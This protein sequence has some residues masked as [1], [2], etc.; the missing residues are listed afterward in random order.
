MHT[1]RLFV[2][3]VS[4]LALL[5][6]CILLATPAAAA[7]CIYVT[8]H[9]SVAQRNVCLSITDALQFINQ[10][11]VQ[12]M[13]EPGLHVLRNTSTGVIHGFNGTIF[14]GM[15]SNVTLTC[16]DNIGLV[17][18][19]SNQLTIQ[20]LTITGCSMGADQLATVTEH[21][22]M[23]FEQVITIPNDLNV[24]L[25]IADS[26]DVRI[27]SVDISRMNG[28]GLVGLN[29]LGETRIS[30][31]K[32]TSNKPITASCPPLD[33]RSNNTD[34]IAGGMFLLYQDYQL[35]TPSQPDTHN[36]L[37]ILNCRFF[38][39]EDCSDVWVP[40]IFN[41]RT[42][43]LDYSFGGGGGMTL[44][45]AQTHYSV[46]SLIQSSNFQSNI[47][48]F[49]SG[50]HIGFFTGSGNSTVVFNK[51]TFLNNGN[52]EQ[53]YSGGGIAVL[54]DLIRPNGT[55]PDKRSLT[56]P[57]LTVTDTNFTGNSA[58]Y[59]GGLYV[60]TLTGSGDIK[61]PTSFKIDRCNFR[62]NR[63]PAASAA[64]VFNR[65]GSIFNALSRT[66]IIDSCFDNN[67]ANFEEAGEKNLIVGVTFLT[68]GGDVV[69]RGNT[70]FNGNLGSA[71]TSSQANIIIDGDITIAN[72]TG[73]VGSLRLTDL[74]KLI[75]KRN[76]VLTFT[77][78]AAAIYG[79]AIYEGSQGS[80]L[81]YAQQ[82]CF[83]Y[84]EQVNTL[85]EIET[86]PDFASL[87]VT[88]IFHDNRAILGTN[89]YGSS[90]EKCSWVHCLRK[91]P[92]NSD[93]TILKALEHINIASVTRTQN[94]SSLEVSTLPSRINIINYT[95]EH[96]MPGQEFLVNIIVYDDLDQSISSGLGSTIRKKDT[97]V[98]ENK[99]FSRLGPNGF[100][101]VDRS[102]NNS[103]VSRIPVTIT[104]NQNQKL[105]VFV[106]S[107]DESSNAIGSFNITLTDCLL[108]FRY[109]SDKQSCVCQPVFD[110]AGVKCRA[111]SGII[112]LYNDTWV[113]LVQD[114]NESRLGYTRCTV[115]FCKVGDINITKDN[116]NQR[117][118]DSLN[119]EG[120]G[121]GQCRANFSSTFGSNQCL[122]CTNYYLFLIIAFIATGIGTMFVLSFF[123]I[124]IAEGYLN[125]VLFYSN[126]ID[127]FAVFLVPPNS[128]YI[129]AFIP[130]FWISQNLG[131]QACFFDGMTTLDAYGLRFAYV[132]YLLILMV[133]VSLLS[134]FIQLPTSFTYS[135][136]KVF[137]TLL[138]LCYISLL[139]T[140]VSIFAFQKVNLDNG[141]VLISWYYDPNVIYFEGIHGVLFALAVITM[142][143]YVI[144]F[145]ILIL[146]PKLILRSKFFDRFKPLLDPFWAPLKPGYEWW[147]AFRLVLRW[148][149]VFLNVFLTSLLSIV[150]TLYILGFCLICLLFMQ[151]KLQPFSGS[152]RN[153]FDDLLL[154]NL[155]LIMTGS[156]PLLSSFGASA[157]GA[158]LPIV[159]VSL[160]YVVFLVIL[161]FQIDQT[162]PDIRNRFSK[163]LKKKKAPA[164][165][166][167]DSRDKS[168]SNENV[169]HSEVVVSPRCKTKGSI[170][171]ASP[172]ADE[173]LCDRRFVSYR[174][175]L[176]GDEE[177]NNKGFLSSINKSTIETS[178]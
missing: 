138:I 146:S 69:L 134:R 115:N 22:E 144:P 126:I 170:R 161:I 113:G 79:G 72:T 91:I 177:E 53:Y 51:C 11:N 106:G 148:I 127:L 164:P 20:D 3:L 125:S 139:E 171:F 154:T 88:M 14:Q 156:V 62:E 45:N 84:F 56:D 89:I 178:V 92:G 61:V 94:E 34:S 85:P 165:E 116:F 30:G 58:F 173:V 114:G 104:G 66:E 80:H 59:G 60:Y 175:S 174:E 24:G 96:V 143:V 157:S 48:K 40:E 43:Q 65:E 37:T 117:C 129:N 1:M 67:D 147:V 49:G 121:C 55:R 163:W 13:F 141:K 5:D 47:A 101:F 75:L 142:V 29:L 100:Q 19:Q 9:A 99:A 152:S 63:A 98:N 103:T 64:L 131:I 153:L 83:L 140:C 109:D 27:E 149:P 123:R 21:A 102:F 172:D 122:E 10:S 158:V 168:P 176:L 86:C 77:G 17:F 70:L 132:A 74:A 82:G 136:T 18:L 95:E 35:D 162:H 25:L 108:G 90:L 28:I 130:L 120:V 160:A 12:L 133:L 38:D 8:G 7:P 50:A 2:P 107:T 73:F 124:S 4:T 118:K 105:T 145:P 31:V 71:L 159:F 6:V 57:L 52:M 151:T 54:V 87:N 33:I 46:R 44:M 36:N 167:S 93:L 112:T 81:R 155:V 119:R 68:R 41:D 32:F 135:P 169:T 76:S 97:I 23:T 110:L 26:R 137:A 128:S 39:N 16:E 42:G 15:G 78:N 166:V 111:E 150:S